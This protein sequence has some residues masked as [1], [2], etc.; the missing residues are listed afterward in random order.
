VY[1]GHEEC[2]DGNNIG[3]DGCSPTC[4]W[5]AVAVAA[6]DYGTCALSAGG[7]VKCWGDGAHGALGQGNTST[8]GD[9]PGELG[10]ALAPV[11]LGKNR[12]AKAISAGTYEA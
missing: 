7:A 4:T 8:L 1:V 5:E 3:G 9:G 6:G 2:D 10:G 11:D 12:I